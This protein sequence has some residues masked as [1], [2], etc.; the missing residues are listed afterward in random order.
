MINSSDKVRLE[1][2][3]EIKNDYDS[4]SKLIIYVQKNV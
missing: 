3:V 1:N 4:S 2:I